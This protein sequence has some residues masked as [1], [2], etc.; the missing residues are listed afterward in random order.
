[1]KEITIGLV[2]M[3]SLCGDI[4]YNL[5][6]IEG[7]VRQAAAKQTD[8][9]CFPELSLTGYCLEK[10]WTAQESKIKEAVKEL[11]NLSMQLKIV[12]MVGM[13]EVSDSS[14]AYISQLICLEDGSCK[15]YRKTHLGQR[16]KKVFAAGNRLPVFKLEA[17]LNIGVELCY[18]THF[19]EVT[20]KLSQMG[21][22]IVFA[23]HA[24]PLVSAGSREEIWGKYIPAR[25]YDNRVYFAC[26]NQLGG[27]G[28]GS[29]F[30]GGCVVYGP[31]GSVIAKD[32]S[33]QEGLLTTKLSLTG[34]ERYRNQGKGKMGAR[35]FL[36]DRRTEL[37]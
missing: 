21:A 5:K 16:E 19:P 17:G 2:Q 4:E 35:F 20:G 10:D 29:E 7:F 23:P 12:I 27:N 11:L 36:Q 30:A 24:V 8:I 32:F 1:M 33:N 15:N 31:D 37:Y 28:R 34:L 3:V 13:V 25:A 26:C 18:D 6:K 14:D 22:Q 9:I